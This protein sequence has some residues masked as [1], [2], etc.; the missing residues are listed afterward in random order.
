MARH[1]SCRPLDSAV[2]WEFEPLQY[3]YELASDHLRYGSL[4]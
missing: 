3:M 1:L 4:R 2:G